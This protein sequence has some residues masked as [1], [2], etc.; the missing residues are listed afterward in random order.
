MHDDMT[1][2]AFGNPILKND[3]LPLKI[4]PELQKHL[5]EI[6]FE[7]K[8]PTEEVVPQENPWWIIDTVKGIT[9]VTLFESLDDFEEKLKTV[10]RISLHDFDL[11]F[12][13]LLL[14]KLH[15]DLQVRI[16]GVPSIDNGR[17]IKDIAAMIHPT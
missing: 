11:G 6:T 7:V 12:H 15:P 16:I 10:S 1:V 3:S 5:P 9:E 2:M 4:L 13:L 8:D 17:V 14:K